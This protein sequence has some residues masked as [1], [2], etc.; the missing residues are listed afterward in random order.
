MY[1]RIIRA[2]IQL[3]RIENIISKHATLAVVQHAVGSLTS[4]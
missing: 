4:N 1:I 3:I 2:D